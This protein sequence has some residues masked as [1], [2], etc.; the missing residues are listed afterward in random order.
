MRLHRSVLLLLATALVAAACGGGGDVQNAGTATPATTGSASPSGLGVAV[1]SFDLATEK[2]AR[3]E[4]GVFTPDHQLIIGGDVQMAFTYVGQDPAASPL[5]AATTTASFLPVPGEEP[6]QPYDQPVL[7][8]AAQ[9]SGV[10]VTHVDLDRPG[11]W[12]VTV[13]ADVKGQGELTGSAAFQVADAHQV[14]AVGDPAP[15]VEN[16]TMGSDAPKA[17]IDSRATTNDGTIPDPI[18]HQ[19]TVA[20][21]IADHRPVVVVLSTPVYCFSRFCGPVTNAVA[22]LARQYGDRADFVHI[23]IWKDF[24]NKQLNDAAAQWIQ[25]PSGQAN[26]PWVFLVGA[27]GTVKARWDNV[28]NKDQL[29]QLLQELPAGQG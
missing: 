28:L 18:L 26:E 2:N 23:E 15:K 4:A 10:Y 11:Y 5:P 24:D 8:Q 13:T 20:Q 19:T 17:A 1:A 16:L 7:N 25:A 9:A 14:P 6:D 27:D 3:F 12:S 29:E 22:D 21:A